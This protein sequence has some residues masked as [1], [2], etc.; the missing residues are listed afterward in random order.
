MITPWIFSLYIFIIA[1]KL[2]KA[3]YS[4]YHFKHQFKTGLQK[5]NVELRLFTELKACQFGIKEK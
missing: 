5:P 1:G 4:W 2:M 3:V